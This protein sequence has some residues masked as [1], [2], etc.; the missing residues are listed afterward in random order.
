MEYNDIRRA[1]ANYPAERMVLTINGGIHDWVHYRHNQSGIAELIDNNH[2]FTPFADRLE[3]DGKILVPIRCWD[4]DIDMIEVLDETT[5]KYHPMWSTDPDYTGGLSRWEHRFYQKLLKSRN[6]GSARQ[7]GR[8]A[9]K[10]KQDRLAAFDDELWKMGMRERSKVCALIAAEEKRAE[11]IA[12]AE[13]ARGD[14]AKR[15]AS[16]P[17]RSMTPAGANRKDIPK[18]PPQSR[19]SVKRKRRQHTPPRRGKDYG[20]ASTALVSR[21]SSATPDNHGTSS[22]TTEKFKFKKR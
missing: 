1:F 7:K 10:A 13:A 9:A 22:K 21:S 6:G 5:G 12:D 18:P 15:G 19:G 11:A 8:I 16:V 2:R 3:E 4:F 20:S 14:G 17:S